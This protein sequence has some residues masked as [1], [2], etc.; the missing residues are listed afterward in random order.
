VTI[1]LKSEEHISE[2]KK[3]AAILSD[4]LSFLSLQVK[5]GMTGLQVDKLTEEFVR[6]HGGI[7]ACKGYKEYPANICVSVNAGAVHCIPN[8]KPFNEGDVVKLDLVVDYNGWKADSATT[9][10][11]PPVKPEIQTFAETTY[12]AMYEGIKKAVDGNR[13]TDI[14]S[15]VESY[16]KS[17]GYGVVE[18]FVGHGIGREIHE[19]PQ[20]PNYLVKEK[21]ALLCEGMTLCIEPITT[22]TSDAL[23][24]INGWDTKSKSGYPVCHFEHTILVTKSK[25]EILTLRKTELNLL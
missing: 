23:V 16:V 5:A 3:A 11:I 21:D 14:S 17:R 19:E 10:L 7:C 15:A 13:I 8:E 2:I 4:C 9:V 1:Y 12:L 18:P 24:E 22:F 6:S 20:V 25:P